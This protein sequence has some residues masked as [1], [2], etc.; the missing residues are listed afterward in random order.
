MVYSIGG[1][2][3]RNIVNLLRRIYIS[4]PTFAH[5]APPLIFKAKHHS[6]VALNARDTC[7]RKQ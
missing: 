3:L 4:M 7:M 2:G 5:T 1:G 6:L